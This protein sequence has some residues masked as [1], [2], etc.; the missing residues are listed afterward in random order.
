MFDKNFLTRKKFSNNVIFLE[1][2]VGNCLHPIR[3]VRD[4]TGQ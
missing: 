4:A 3:L 2:V 1:G